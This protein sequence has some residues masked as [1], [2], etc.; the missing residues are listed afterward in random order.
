MTDADVRSYEK[1]RNNMDFEH[2]FQQAGF[3]SAL[4]MMIAA[5]LLAPGVM[6]RSDL[7]RVFAGKVATYLVT[8]GPISMLIYVLYAVSR[9]S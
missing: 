4:H 9:L 3:L 5:S 8:F 7:Y 6:G 1:G 2:V